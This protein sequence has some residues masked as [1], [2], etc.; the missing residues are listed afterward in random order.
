MAYVGS[1]LAQTQRASLEGTVQDHSG[2]IIPGA[3]VTLRDEETNQTRTT[4]TD[5]QGWYRF[6]KVPVGTCEVRVDHEGFAPFAYG[7]LVLTIG[8]TARLTVGMRPAG[9][10][11]TVVVSAQP[12]PLDSRRTSVATAIDTERIEELPVRSRNYLEF[13]LLAPAV[14]RSRLETTAGGATST[15]PEL[16]NDF[17]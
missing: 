7:G 16:P 2:G 4:L 17:Q 1:V 12:P 8:R 15:L 11:E 14:T 13:V 6:T 5:S 10:T 3:T 9:V